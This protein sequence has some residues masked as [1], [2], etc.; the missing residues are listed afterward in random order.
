MVPPYIEA[1]GVPLGHV[2]PSGRH[3]G[4]E[5]GLIFVIVIASLLG[6]VAVLMF[7]RH[8]FAPRPTGIDA[9]RTPP[10][11]SHSRELT[12]TL[13][14]YARRGERYPASPVSLA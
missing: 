11:I 13:G 6:V 2:D 3:T 10:A 12:D 4:S 14:T 1:K 7:L 8:G 9:R 5:T